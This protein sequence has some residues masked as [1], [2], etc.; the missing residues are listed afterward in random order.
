MIES[1]N[2]VYNWFRNYSLDNYNE[3]YNM[4]VT[5]TYGKPLKYDYQCEIPIRNLRDYLLNRNVFVDGIITTEYNSGFKNLHNHILMY[6][7]S[8][9]HL[10]KGMIFN[11]WK[12]I[13]NCY[14][15]MFDENG[16]QLEYITKHLYKTENNNISFMNDL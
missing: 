12:R 7:D 8:D 9:F 3:D 6:S 10:T 11:F 16:T 13:G 2:E 4:V 5:L 15:D 14:F 1:R